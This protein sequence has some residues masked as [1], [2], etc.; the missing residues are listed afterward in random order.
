LYVS[1]HCPPEAESKYITE[2]AKWNSPASKK[3]ELIAQSTALKAQTQATALE[4]QL[5][6]A[7]KKAPELQ[8]ESCEKYLGL[9]A[10]VPQSAVLKQLWDAA[11]KILKG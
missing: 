3:E 7:L 5:C 11:Q 8:K 4:S 1:C 2:L 10:S 6:R 9:Y